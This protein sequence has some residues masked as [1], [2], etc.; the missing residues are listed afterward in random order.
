M[1][2]GEKNMTIDTP[3]GP[4]TAAVNGEGALTQ[5]KFGT[6]EKEGNGAGNPAV[7]RQLSEYFS[8]KRKT[9]D[10]PLAPEGTEFQ[11]RIWAELTLIPYGETISYA[12][13]AKRAGRTGAARAVGRANATNPIAIV[14]PCHRVIGADGSLTGYAYGVEVKRSLLDFERRQAPL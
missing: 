6:P 3:L 9:F 7:A 4:V 11:K 13:L 5:L 12:E 8:G 14:V 10:L 2:I 1:I